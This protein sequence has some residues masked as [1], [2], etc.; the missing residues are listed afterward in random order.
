MSLLGSLPLLFFSGVGAFSSR[1]GIELRSLSRE[2]DSLGFSVAR[3]SSPRN[4][5]EAHRGPIARA[6]PFNRTSNLS[7]PALRETN[8]SRA[9]DHSS[10]KVSKMLSALVLNDA[11]P[12]SFADVRTARVARAR[13]ETY[14]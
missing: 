11:R 2:Q 14:G 13:F 5:C 10:T 4:D 9:I 6:T 3:V 7:H 1:M 12:Y 8:Y